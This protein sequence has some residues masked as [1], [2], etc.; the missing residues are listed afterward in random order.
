MRPHTA[1]TLRASKEVDDPHIPS[2][3]VSRFFSQS[4]VPRGVGIRVLSPARH[5]TE[6]VPQQIERQGTN[7]R[8][9]SRRR[10]GGPV[11]RTV[12]PAGNPFADGPTGPKPNVLWP[13]QGVDSDGLFSRACGGH[14]SEVLWLHSFA[15]LRTLLTEAR[16]MR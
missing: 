3:V 7:S 16:L 14:G 2:H 8:Y 1:R 11:P 15:A 13:A 9:W 12:S 6:L 4:E 5:D 10:P